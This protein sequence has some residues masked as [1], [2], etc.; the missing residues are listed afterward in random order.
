VEH[1]VPQRL[2]RAIESI[3]GPWTLRNALMWAGLIGLVLVFRWL[4][5]EPYSI[6]TG[7]MEPTLHGDPRLLRGD[8]IAVNKLVY[9]PRVPFMQKRLFRLW[10]PRRWDIVVF[11]S[12][13]PNAA[14]PTLV[15]R[16]VGLPGERIHIAD[17]KIHV[18]GLAVEPPPELRSVLNYTT[19]LKR[20]REDVQ[21]FILQLIRRSD[22]FPAML[23]PANQGVQDLMKELNAIREQLNGRGTDTLSQAEIDDLLKGLSP[24]SLY[25]V[26]ELLGLEQAAQFPLRYGVRTEDEYAVVPPGC[27]LV[28][29][30]NS[31]DSVDGRY[32]GWLPND[33]IYGRVVCTW[34]P[35]DRWRDFTGFSKTWWGKGILYGP[36]ALLIAWEGLAFVRRRRAR[37][38]G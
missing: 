11:H 16:V 36:P 24:L 38:G 12:P 27:Y 8:R 30:D 9:G 18:N 19:Q 37:N 32:F 22:A 2:K 25:I 34:W 6:P 20:S 5:M 13:D 26:E 33:N 7:S 10:E 31:G 21:A 23:N 4:I 1:R 14:H 15:K 17:G 35:V 28:L 29:G 3:T